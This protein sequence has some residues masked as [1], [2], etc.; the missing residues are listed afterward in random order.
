[1]RVSIVN[2]AKKKAKKATK[3]TAKPWEKGLRAAR[4]A[5]KAKA[6]GKASTPAKPRKK[7]RKAAKKATK[8]RKKAPKAKKAKATV[9]KPQKKKRKTSKKAKV[10]HKP[11]KKAKRKKSRKVIFKSTG[12]RTRPV[13]YRKGK[14]VTHSPASKFARKGY[15]FNPAMSKH[16]VKIGTFDN[17]MT[18]VRHAPITHIAGMAGGFIFSGYAG[19]KVGKFVQEQTKNEIMGQIGSVAGNLIGTEV[20]AMIVHWGFPKVGLN[21]YAV[22]V[23]RGM[24]VGGYIALGLN[25]FTLALKILKVPVPFRALGDNATMKEFVLSG[26]GDVD[27]I[28]AGISG[29][30]FDNSSDYAALDNESA[31]LVDEISALSEYING[32]SDDFAGVASEAASGSLTDL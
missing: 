7:K 9:T 6:M 16:M 20:P 19:G 26:L 2:P 11:K 8:K 5:R 3:K 28:T 1:M 21:K 13:M 17:Y 10:A 30:N 14:K 18:D 12:Q 4:K 24:R 23:A 25:V 29:V 15:R 31:G 32:D 22:P 27:L